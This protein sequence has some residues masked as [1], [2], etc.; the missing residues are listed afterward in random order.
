MAVL[1][2]ENLNEY[3]GDM[4]VFLGTLNNYTK[5]PTNNIGGRLRVTPKC[6]SLIT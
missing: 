2:V 5:Y 3:L 6:H 1:P 4:S